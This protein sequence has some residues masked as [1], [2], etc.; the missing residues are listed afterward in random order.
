MSSVN[1]AP[2]PYAPPVAPGGVAENPGKTLGIVALVLAIFLN[3]VG[4]I[5][6]IVA[7]LK[8]KKAGYPNGFALAAIIV[9]FALFV[10]LIVVIVVLFVFTAG[11][12]SDLLQQCAG[13][14]GEQIVIQGQ[15]VTC[16]V[17]S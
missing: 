14:G 2:Q 8:S 12:T 11:V 5:V 1:D 16:P 4:A 3:I 15:T 9:G 13:N 10:L 6:G 7:L 17:G